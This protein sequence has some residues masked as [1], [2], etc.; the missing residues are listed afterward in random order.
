MNWNDEVPE[1]IL[2]PFDRW[3]GSI[4]SLK[5]VQIP[6]WASKLGLEDAVNE[7]VIFCDAS[8]TGYGIV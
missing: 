6:R 5:S 4:D 3:K 1:E 7:L 2:K 8:T